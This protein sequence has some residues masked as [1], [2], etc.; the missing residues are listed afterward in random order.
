MTD[1][2]PACE[3]AKRKV[4]KALILES[5]LYVVL[6]KSADLNGSAVCLRALAC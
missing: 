6:V 4:Q 2:V 5:L 3:W 1:P